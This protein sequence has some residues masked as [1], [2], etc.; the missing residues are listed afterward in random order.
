MA[1]IAEKP[2]KFQLYLSLRT[3]LVI[4]LVVLLTIFFAGVGYW[5]VDF[6]V[7]KTY[8]QIKQQLDDTL[9][10]TAAGVSGDDIEQLYA[11]VLPYSEN[12]DY[13]S[14]EYQK[15]IEFISSDPVYQKQ[16]NW[17][18]TIHQIAPRAYPFIFAKG[19]KEHE[20][21]FLVDVWKIDPVEANRNRS[22]QFGE[23]YLPDF[24]PEVLTKTYT[25]GKALFTIS[26]R[27][28][29]ES[30]FEFTNV[31]DLL[32]YSDQWGTWVSGFAAIKNSKGEVVG[33]I[34]VDFDAPY[35]TQARDDITK[36]MGVVFLIIYIV[37]I[38][39][40]IL[41]AR[42]FTQPISTLTR[43]VELL[44]EGK[45]TDQYLHSLQ[46]KI[47]PNEMTKL[48]NA[49]NIMSSQIKSSYDTLEGKVSDRTSE[50]E[51]QKLELERVNKF[52]VDRELKMIEMK[53]EIEKLKKTP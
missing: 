42:A 39:I 16:L 43:A 37:S 38:V 36:S 3:Q 26:D 4:S 2:K 28:E 32:K 7:G 24:H 48:A 5:F 8:D 53:N 47:F 46:N 27:S 22:T 49:F 34:G 25:E 14:S 50:L 13:K 18:K 51:K 9:V 15:S 33:G 17:L 35:V 21:I 23:Y 44:S 10:G 6:T 41:V 1:Q 40:A 29:I 19:A 20:M 12:T 52:M 31:G 11:K 45:F 30:P